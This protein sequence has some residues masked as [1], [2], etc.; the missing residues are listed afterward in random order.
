MCKLGILY[1]FAG[2]NDY[3]L[4]SLPVRGAG[5]EIIR[6]THAACER[7]WLPVGVAGVDRK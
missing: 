2:K 6:V 3:F 4:R 5:I 7:V 1:I